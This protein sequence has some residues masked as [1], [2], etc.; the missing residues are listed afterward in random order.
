M[1]QVIGRRL[2]QIGVEYL[3]GFFDFQNVNVRMY[4]RTESTIIAL[5][6]HES[7]AE[8]IKPH[9]ALHVPGLLR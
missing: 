6:A 3:C 4:A 7:E 2:T 5:D 8:G 1:K 9:V